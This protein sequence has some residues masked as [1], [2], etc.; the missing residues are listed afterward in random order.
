ML[1]IED[2]A[3]RGAGVALVDQQGA[4]LE[5]VAVALQ[6]EIDDGV[7]QRM[8]G[9]DEGGGRLALRGNQGRPAEGTV[10]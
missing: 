3:R 7:E 8:A 10:T 1:Q 6:G 5:Q 9:A 2:H 4:V